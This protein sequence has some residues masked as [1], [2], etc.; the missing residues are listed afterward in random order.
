LRGR[1]AGDGCRHSYRTRHSG[2]GQETRTSGRL[3]VVNKQHARNGGTRAALTRLG[4]GILLS[5]SLPVKQEKMMRSMD[6]PSGTD[7]P[8][9]ARGWHAASLSGILAPTGERG[10]IPQGFKRPLQLICTCRLG[11]RPGPLG[12]RCAAERARQG[13]PRQGVGSQATGQVWQKRGIVQSPRGSPLDIL[14]HVHR[15]IRL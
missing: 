6:A 11:P 3:L 1:H 8:H 9:C 5:E 2:D 10:S 14:S 7:A 13:D 15:N 12:K 4:D